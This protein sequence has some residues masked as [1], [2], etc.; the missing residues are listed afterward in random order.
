[1]EYKE[2]YD[3]YR[4]DNPQEFIALDLLMAVSD[5]VELERQSR[6]AEK[7]RRIEECKRLTEERRNGRKQAFI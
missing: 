3:N 6:R 4:K 1:M 7:M 5:K 2:V